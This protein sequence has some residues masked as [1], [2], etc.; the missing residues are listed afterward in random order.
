MAAGTMR[1]LILGAGLTGLTCGVL[2]ARDGHQVTII[3]RDPLPPQVETGDAW[4]NWERPGVSQFRQPHLMLPRWHAEISRELPELLD[5]LERIGAPRT[6][7]LHLR[8]DAV[9][10][11]W[12]PGDERFETVAVRRPV[13]ESVLAR[14]AGEQ[15]RLTV[16]RG[17]R[18]TGLILDRA[19]SIPQCQ[20][21]VTTAGVVRAD[22]VID[23]TG[24]RTPVPTW[25]RAHGVPG[26]VE[27]RADSGFVYYSRYFHHPGRPP[28][29]DRYV[30]SHHPSWSVLTLPGDRRTSCV[31][32]LTSDRDRQA[33]SLRHERI[34]TAVVRCL[35]NTAAWVQDAHPLTTVMPIAGIEDIRRSYL[36]TD[37]PIATDILAIG[38]SAIATNPALGRGATIGV[39]Q[40][41]A[42]RDLLAKPVGDGRE[43]ARELELE[44]A[45][46]AGAWAENS[47]RFT[48]NRLAEI[49]ADIAGV[50]YQSDDPTWAMTTALLRGA[51]H[52]PVLAR[53]SSSIGGMLRLPHEVFGDPSL[54]KRVAT[55]MNTPRYPRDAPTRAHLVQATRGLA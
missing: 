17:V 15:S 51:D 40:S 11:G 16:R 18:A 43:L 42:L 47:I 52:D 3:E 46:S 25:L 36:R 26:P 21:I 8:G 53:A 28:R 41:A 34:W 24:R 31:V 5:R 45:T 4:E 33:R 48:R 2:L 32:L 30:L 7:L 14:L 27:E 20:G 50:A 55:Y 38:D 1:I 54:T 37:E 44:T 49:D 12:Q 23:A 13:L 35:P 39:L 10:G 29:G 9:T 6:N 19:P 22:L